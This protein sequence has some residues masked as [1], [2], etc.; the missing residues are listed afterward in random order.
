MAKIN[1]RDEDLKVGDV[2]DLWCGAKRIT[3]IE[4]YTGPL[5]DIIFAIATYTPGATK[6]YGGIS[7]ERGGYTDVITI[8]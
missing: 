8:A 5:T 2:I 3:A 6:L 7:L 1:T 4:P